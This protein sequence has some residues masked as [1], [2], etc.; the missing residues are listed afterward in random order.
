MRHPLVARLALAPALA[1]AFAPLGCSPAAPSLDHGS[2]S[3]TIAGAPWTATTALTAT[4]DGT[5]LTITGSDATTSLTLAISKDD[6]SPLKSGALAINTSSAANATLTI[7]S[8]GTT[9]TLMAGA[10]AGSGGG[11]VAISSLTSVTAVGTFSLVFAKS[12]IN[13]GISVTDG[14]FSVRF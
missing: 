3:A 2:M 4:F 5:V 10:V 9:Q 7:K 13:G 14:T 11:P 12:G 1:L 6:G 8:A